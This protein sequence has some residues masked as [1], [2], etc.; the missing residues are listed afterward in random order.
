MS[1]L[2]DALGVD[3][4]DLEW[5][6]LA[7][8]QGTDTSLFYEQYESDPDTAVLVDE[9]CLSCPV[10][11]RCLSAGMDND[12]Y[13]TWGGF[14]LTAGKVDANRNAH[15]TDEVKRRLRARLVNAL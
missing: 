6:D 12:E 13:G 7:Y 9:M 8:C 10:L 1:N 5:E 15:K 2:Y 4:D 11:A 14:Y 3:P